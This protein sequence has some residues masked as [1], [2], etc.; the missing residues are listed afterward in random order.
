MR[1]LSAGIGDGQLHARQCATSRYD[2]CRFKL[3]TVWGV[4][5]YEQIQSGKSMS[6]LCLRG[7]E[8]HRTRMRIHDVR[9]HRTG[10]TLT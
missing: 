5:I 7:H 1:I 8:R 4:G 6:K 2:W 9:R 10:A 3:V